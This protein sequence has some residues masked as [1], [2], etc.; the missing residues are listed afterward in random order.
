VKVYFNVEGQAFAATLDEDRNISR[1]WIAE[2]WRDEIEDEHN[3][4]WNNLTPAFAEKL[5]QA[6]VDAAGRES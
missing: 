2:G 6:A 5:S 3:V 4:I 1:L